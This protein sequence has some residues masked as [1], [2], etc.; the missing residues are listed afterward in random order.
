MGALGV[1]LAGG[2]PDPFLRPILIGTF[3]SFFTPDLLLPTGASYLYPIH[4]QQAAGFLF[5]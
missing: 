1:R 5:K 4:R 3:P 2:R